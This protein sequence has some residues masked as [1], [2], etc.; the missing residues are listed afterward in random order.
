MLLE[1]SGGGDRQPVGA[2]VRYTTE[3]HVVCSNFIARLRPAAGFDS[4]FLTY[5]HA[6]LYSSGVAGLSIKQTT[7]IQN[8]DVG[9]YLRT[10]VPVPRYRVQRAI[11]NFL[12]REIQRIDA[13][14]EKKQRLRGRLTERRLAVLL[15][16]VDGRLTVAGSP[17][18]ARPLP[19]LDSLP[20]DWPTIKLSF[21]AR[22]GSG[23][24]PSRTH[25]EYWTDCT[26]PWITTGEVAQVRDDRREVITQTRERISELGLANSAAELHPA[27]TVVLCRTASAGYSAIMGSDMATSQ[28]FATWTCSPRLLPRFLLTCLRAMRS[29][30]LGRLAMGSTH[31]TIYMPDIQAL[32]IPLPPVKG[33]QA[34]LDA[35]DR[36]L[37]AIDPL[38]QSLD[39]QI[40]LLYERRQALI[41]EVVTGQRRIDEPTP[42]VA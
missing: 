17:R 5:L 37:R 7:G 26:I 38:R 22:L 35:A 27:G 28:D 40:R 20:V 25:P 41:T 30:L 3:E 34:A 32:R 19:W 23:H 4:G 6:A 11:A 16:A 9:H 10:V 8:M 1:K 18:S 21:V 31:K 13:L 24:T 15:Y 33:Q 29:D 42:A 12:D 2:V 39:A 14:I 36:E